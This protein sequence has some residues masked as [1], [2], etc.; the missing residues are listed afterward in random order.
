ML[1]FVA[2]LIQTSLH[3]LCFLSLLPLQPFRRAVDDLE[4]ACE[5][6]RSA[7]SNTRVAAIVDILGLLARFYREFVPSRCGCLSFSRHFTM[8]FFASG[9][10]SGSAT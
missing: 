5:E 6:M 1:L 3:S 10:S 2:M 9:S 4:K 7:S 8:L